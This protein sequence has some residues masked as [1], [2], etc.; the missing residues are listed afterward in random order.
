MS[1]ENPHKPTKKGRNRAFTII[2]IVLCLTAIGTSVFFF[3]KYRQAT[4]T[5]EAAN[6]QLVEQIG[7]TL[8]LPDETPTV[9]TVTDRDKLTNKSLADHVQ[10]DDKLLV[11]GNAKKLIVYRPT[12]KKVIDIL[13]FQSTKDVLAN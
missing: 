4:H 6:K 9:V 3:I 2:L 12:A 11:F 8:Q 1:D 5:E 13:T 10:N 7:Q